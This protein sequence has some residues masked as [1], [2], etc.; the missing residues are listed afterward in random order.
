MARY[1]ISDIHGCL[2][3]FQVMV[4]EELSLQPEDHLYLLG[5]YINKGP[6]SKGVLDYILQLREKG[7]QVT[8]LRGNHDQLLLDAVDEGEHTLWL[9]PEDREKTMESFGVKQLTDIPLRYLHFIRCMPLLVVLDDYILVHAGVN[10]SLSNPLA[11][12]NH[13]LLN[14]RAAKASTKKLGGKVLVHGHLP[15]PRKKIEKVVKN[16]KKGINLDAGCV[17]FK[18][19]EFGNLCA[20]NLDT[21]KLHWQKNIDLPYSIKMK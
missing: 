4:E 1:A 15:V 20:L 10:M 19:K 16:P 3:T 18:N 14:T 8:C 17:Y 7:F 13:T 9:K 12:P 11:T 21:L 6:E 2:R 5:D